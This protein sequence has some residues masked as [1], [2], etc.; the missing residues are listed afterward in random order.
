MVHVV[1]RMGTAQHNA[2]TRT[3]PTAPF[4]SGCSPWKTTGDPN[5]RFAS[6]VFNY[7]ARPPQKVYRDDGFIL[8]APGRLSKN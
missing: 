6:I 1:A 5:R 8:N 2:H 3:D 4:A 7:R